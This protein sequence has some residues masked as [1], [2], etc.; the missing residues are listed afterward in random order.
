MR[1]GTR[2]HAGR[3]LLPAF[4]PVLAAAVVLLVAR[5]LWPV[6]LGLGAVSLLALA[7]GRH[8]EIRA[9]ERDLDEAF[10]VADRRDV[11]LRRSL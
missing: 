7:F 9:W 5:S 2:P 1:N 11:P 10:G 3:A 6:A 8:H 4:A